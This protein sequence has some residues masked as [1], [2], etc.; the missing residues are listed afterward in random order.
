[1]SDE[2]DALEAKIRK[3]KGPEEVPDHSNREGVQAGLE[4]V[5]SILVGGAI[6]YGLDSFFGTKPL[7]MIIFFL[8]GTAAGFLS[9]YRISQN[10]GSSVGYAAQHKKEQEKLADN[11]L[12]GV[13]KDAK[14]TAKK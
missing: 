13:K 1:M 11:D 5:L 2:L 9:I 4:L 6:G 7:F 12:Q 14:Q 10:L 3:A 8:M